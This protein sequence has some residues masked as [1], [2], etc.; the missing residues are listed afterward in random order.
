ML[1]FVQNDR[2][3]DI[4]RRSPLYL[5]FAVDIITLCSDCQLL[6]PAISQRDFPRISRLVSIVTATHDCRVNL[7]TPGR[8]MR[9]PRECKRLVPTPNFLNRPEAQFFYVFDYI[10]KLS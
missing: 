7:G 4:M 5:S 10:E 8:L 6:V 1:Y 9:Q 3:F 2:S